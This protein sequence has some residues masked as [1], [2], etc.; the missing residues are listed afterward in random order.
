MSIKIIVAFDFQ[1]KAEALHI[2]DYLDKE[3]F[4][5]KIGFE[6]FVRYGPQLVKEII[7]KGFK[8]FLDLK[9]HDIPQTVANACKS[10]ADLGVWM[11]NVHAYGGIKML[12]S[13]KNSLSTYKEKPLLIGVTILTSLNSSDLGISANDFQHKVYDLCSLV[14]KAGLDGVVCSALEVPFIKKSFGKNFITVTPGI[15]ISKDNT[16]DQKRVVTPEEALKLGSDYLVIGRSIT[17]AQ[18]PAKT[19]QKLEE[20]LLNYESKNI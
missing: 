6:M 1:E 10:A 17:K 13:A 5:A 12:E 4:A 7:D 8:V 19:V 2:L 16:N 3:R 14:Q 9:F 11:I 20:L 18:D 15:R